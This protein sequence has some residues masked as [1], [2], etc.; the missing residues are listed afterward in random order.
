MTIHI[1]SRKS[2]SAN[3]NLEYVHADK[4]VLLQTSFLV[5]L[6]KQNVYR[7]KLKKKLNSMKIWNGQ[8][9]TWFFSSHAVSPPSNFPLAVLLMPAW[10][11]FTRELHAAHGG[12]F[13]FFRSSCFSFLLT[14]SLLVTIE[15][16]IKST[17]HSTL[18]VGTIVK[19]IDDSLI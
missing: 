13:A 17:R 18:Q 3:F 2:D 19:V 4:R 12:N 8:I 10:K 5:T 16:E 14:S 9:S 6:P 7:G 15:A 1:T 11:D